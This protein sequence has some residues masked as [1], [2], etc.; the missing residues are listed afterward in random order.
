MA[1]PSFS[2][3]VNNLIAVVL[4]HRAAEPKCKD[5]FHW[6]SGSDEHFHILKSSDKISGIF[7]V[8]CRRRACFYYLFARFNLTVSIFCNINNMISCIHKSMFS[9]WNFEII[10]L[11]QY[12][13]TIMR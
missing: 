7:M 6:I 8:F 10:R 11:N 4:S 1:N 9:Y 5:V 12:V 2:M 13:A 3:S